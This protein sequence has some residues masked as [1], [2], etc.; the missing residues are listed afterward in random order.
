[1]DE[2]VDFDNG[3]DHSH[4]GDEDDEDDDDEV[5]PSKKQ[6]VEDD[7]DE[8][9][10][11]QQEEQDQQ[12]EDDIA[13]ED[14]VNND[15]DNDDEDIDNG[16]N[17]S[18]DTSEDRCYC[19]CNNINDTLVRYNRPRK[20]SPEWL[21]IKTPTRTNYRDIFTNPKY[22]NLPQCDRWWE[23]DEEIIQLMA[24]CRIDH[25][26]FRWASARLKLSH[27]F[28][29]DIVCY[30]SMA[31]VGP[32]TVLAEEALAVLEF[33]D[34]RTL[35]DKA[36]FR[37]ALSKFFRTPEN[38]FTILRYASDRLK[39]NGLFFAEWLR[40]TRNVRALGFA[41]PQLK[42]DKAFM[43]QCASIM[44]DCSVL[45]YAKWQ[46]RDDKKFLLELLKA[47]SSGDGV[48]QWAS[49]QLN[50]DEDFVLSA[51]AMSPNANLQRVSLRLRNDKSFVMNWM[52]MTGDYNLNFV[53]QRLQ[54][55]QAVV[56]C[57]LEMGTK[58]NLDILAGVRE[59][60]GIHDPPRILTHASERLCDDDA[61]ARKAMLVSTSDF[62]C[63]SARLRADEDFVL[64]TLKAWKGS[65]SKQ[66][67]YDIWDYVHVE[68]QRQ[69]S[70]LSRAVR[71]CPYI[72]F[73]QILRSPELVM[74]ALGDGTAADDSKDFW[75][76]Y[77]GRDKYYLQL[78]MFWSSLSEAQYELA[79]LHTKLVAVGGEGL[80]PLTKSALARRKVCDGFTANIF[81]ADLWK[82]R[83][84]ERIWLVDQ[85]GANLGRDENAK[86]TKKL[87]SDILHRIV[88]FA[89]FNGILKESRSVYYWGPLI[90]LLVKRNLVLNDPEEDK[91][92]VDT[93]DEE[94]ET[95]YSSLDDAVLDE[96]DF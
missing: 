76:D 17:E 47:A 57:A 90:N 87:N 88:E 39:D 72:L 42:K 71:L 20:G 68:L 15:N 61:L 36:F 62:R 53:P 82:Q 79:S 30:R 52:Q 26:V 77:F 51:G 5:P 44:D 80:L 14:V 34:P 38:S 93:R 9:E 40:G 96:H 86:A 63:V 16:G 70:F 6:R 83:Q 78:S 25:D 21:S 81:S 89:N 3:D 66:K 2:K 55:D 24:M 48:L 92:S 12:E 41:S 74:K 46:L 35:D 4:H 11:Q 7:P 31:L 13:Q 54:D 67:Y 1:M 60:G 8:E 19:C 27:S 91:S 29:L 10:Q 22:A 43:L 32:G 69:S 65:D 85:L 28:V 58:N 75:L 59:R 50:D 73:H 23:D 84:W 33:C 18:D 95:S 64:F 37:V 94:S 49:A 56:L 45:E